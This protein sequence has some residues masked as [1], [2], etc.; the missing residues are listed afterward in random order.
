MSLEYEP[1]SKPLH[2]SEK[3]LFSNT[4]SSNRGECFWQIRFR[5]QPIRFSCTLR[6]EGMNLL[7][8]KANSHNRHAGSTLVAKHLVLLLLLLYYSQ[9]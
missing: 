4:I 5:G 2:I 3:Y 6:L 9:D 1:S 8:S 7:L